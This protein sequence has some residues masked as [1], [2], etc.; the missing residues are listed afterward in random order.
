MTY[1]EHLEE[2][3]KISLADPAQI[4]KYILRIK[5]FQLVVSLCAKWFSIT[6]KE[7]VWIK[8]PERPVE[9]VE[10]KAAREYNKAASSQMFLL[11][12]V[13]N[14]VFFK[15][16]AECRN[17]ANFIHFQEIVK[18]LHESEHK[19]KLFLL[20]RQDEFLNKLRQQSEPVFDCYNFDPNFKQRTCFGN[21]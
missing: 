13:Q 2:I 19:A 7:I 1:Q 12:N 15:R 14:Y 10:Y 8:E 4:K 17:M 21:N 11:N 20:E 16:G 18:D 3:R 5:D 9:W 6:S